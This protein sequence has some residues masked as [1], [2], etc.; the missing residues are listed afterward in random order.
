M[1]EFLSLLVIPEIIEGV[2]AIIGGASVIAS[3]TPTKKDDAILSKVSSIIHFV[4]FNFLKA[5]K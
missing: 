1:L 3:V 2:L 4:A 5:K